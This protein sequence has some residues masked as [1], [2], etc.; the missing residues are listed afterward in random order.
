MIDYIH[1][2]NQSNAGKYWAWRSIASSGD[3][4]KLFAVTSRGGVW[5]SDDG[6]ETWTEKTE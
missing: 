5:G 6:G 3:G 1:Q 2:L 4:M